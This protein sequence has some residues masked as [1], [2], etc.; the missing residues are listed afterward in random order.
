METHGYGSQ[1]ELT[2][3]FYKPKIP[4]R[5][6]TQC[7]TLS[8]SSMLFL[9]SLLPTESWDSSSASGTSGFLPGLLSLSSGC[10]LC[11]ACRLSVLAGPSAWPMKDLPKAS[12]RSRC[13]AAQ[14]HSTFP[15]PPCIRLQRTSVASGALSQLCGHADQALHLSPWS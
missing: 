2:F 5:T 4:N 3:C 6:Q 11:T 9:L 10:W 14:N 7:S 13:S 12:F 15:I 1:F 8:T